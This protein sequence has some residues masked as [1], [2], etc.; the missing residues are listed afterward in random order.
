MNKMTPV[1]AL[2][3]AIGLLEKAEKAPTVELGQLYV[4]IA[5]RWLHIAAGLA[6]PP[7]KGNMPL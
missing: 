4:A 3:N 6:P 2:E 7:S 5:D 1:E